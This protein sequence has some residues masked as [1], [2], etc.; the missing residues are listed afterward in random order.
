MATID[1]SAEEVKEHAEGAARKASPIVGRVARAGYVAKGVVYLAVGLLAGRVAFGAGG[2]PVGTG[3]ALETIGSQPIGKALLVLLVPGLLGY[4]LW[5][6]VQGVMDPDDKGKSVGGLVRRG[7]YVGSALIH[8]GL[9]FSAVEELFGSEG[10]STSIDQWTAR[11]M[12]Q[13]FGRWVVALVGLAVI[14]VGLYQLYAGLTAKYRDEIRTY[15]MSE[16]GWQALLLGRVGTAARA[17]VIL[18]AGFFVLLAAYNADPE[19]TRGLGGTLEALVQQRFGPY[20]LGV[21]AAGF[22]SYGVFMLL[23][24][25]HRRIEAT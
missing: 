3:G 18:M 25:R 1:S 16:A 7:G 6:L 23:V 13:P 21:A 24:A 20:L 10:H 15:Q 11:V 8:G 12:A 14:G 19:R 22:L 4:A 9:A 5:K 17:V 2:Q